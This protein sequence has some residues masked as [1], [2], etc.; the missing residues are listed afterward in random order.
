MQWVRE[1]V[2]EIFGD[3]AN[4]GALEIRDDDAPQFVVAHGIAKYFYAQQKA[5]HLLLSKISTLDFAAL[6]RRADEAATLRATE[7]FSQAVVDT[8]RD[9]PGCTASTMREKFID[10]MRSMNPDNAAYV[11]LFTDEFFNSLSSHVRDAIRESINETFGVSLPLDGFSMPRF[12]F[13]ISRWDDESLSPGGG[14]YEKISAA[15]IA[16]KSSFAF[17]FKWDNPRPDAERDEMARY[18]RS[19]LISDMRTIDF[20]YG[21][22][23]DELARIQMA[24]IKRIATDLFYRH[25]L[26]RTTF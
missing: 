11:R 22:D 24:E 16:S 2:K 12:T 21:F 25:Q 6:Y 14:I 5:L 9:I 3:P 8:I 13:P 26:F 10:M 17:I 1:D 19:R 18:V 23:I 4:P 7:D 20:S 15:L